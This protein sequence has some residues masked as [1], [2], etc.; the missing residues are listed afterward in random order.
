MGEIKK[1]HLNEEQF[2]LLLWHFDQYKRS[3]NQ[4][5]DREL[6]NY[7][8]IQRKKFKKLKDEVNKFWEE[9]DKLN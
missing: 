3:L 1:E 4:V 5:S 6:N 2:V 9:L 8:F 7:N